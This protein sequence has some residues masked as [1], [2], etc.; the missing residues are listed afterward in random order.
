MD[1]RQFRL[2]SYV[3]LITVAGTAGDIHKRADGFMTRV[4][5]LKCALGHTWLA[6]GP[7]VVTPGPDVKCL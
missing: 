7:Q 5:S 3:D 1:R 6:L 2:V 4:Y